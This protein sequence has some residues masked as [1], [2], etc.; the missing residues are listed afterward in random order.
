MILTCGNQS[1][2]KGKARMGTKSRKA[3]SPVVASIILIAVAVALSIA[4]GAWTG[5]L[6]FG[7]TSTEQLR[8]SSMTFDMPSNTITVRVENPGAS[9]VT[10]NEAWVNNVKQNSTN[11]VL[12]EVVAANSETVLNITLSS[13][14]QGY[15]YQ[16]GLVSAKA[17]KF[18]YTAHT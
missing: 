5:A 18:L 7:F 16:V 13:L 1:Q 2:A 11:P 9:V 14:N 10:I 3:L 17:N 6:T 15:N 12:P 4:V 8:I